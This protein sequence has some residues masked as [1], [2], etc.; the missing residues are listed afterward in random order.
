MSEC[1]A[2][3]NWALDELNKSR[4]QLKALKIFKAAMNMTERRRDYST[5]EL[6]RLGIELKKTP[7][8][9]SGS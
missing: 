5:S 7:L 3:I 2:L 9:E 8:C 4:N 6:Q 1:I